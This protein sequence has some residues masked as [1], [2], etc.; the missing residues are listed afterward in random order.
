MLWKN[1]SQFHTYQ[2][3]LGI[4]RAILTSE[5]LNKVT[6]YAKEFL[7]EKCLFFLKEEYSYLKL[8]GFLGTPF[9]LPKFLIHRI[10]ISYLCT[11]YY[12]SPSLNKIVK[13]S[14]YKFHFQL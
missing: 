2:F 5:V 13:D 6:R 8:Y 7:E 12:T 1:K 14:L 10:F 3:H 9:L 11:Q 4:C